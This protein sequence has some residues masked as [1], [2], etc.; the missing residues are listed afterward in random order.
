MARKAPLQVEYWE[1]TFKPARFKTLTTMVECMLLMQTVPASIPVISRS[2]WERLL[3]NPDVLLP[4]SVD[5]IKLVV[6]MV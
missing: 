3:G 1:H 4:V 2:V 6:P 5:N